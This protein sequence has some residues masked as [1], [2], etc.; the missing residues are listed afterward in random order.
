MKDNEKTAK[1]TK[2]PKKEK[3]VKKQKGQKATK[4]P[5]D[6]SQKKKI[7]KILLLLLPLVLILA[8]AAGAVYFFFFR[9]P[10]EEEQIQKLANKQDAY[11]V[12]EDQVISLEKALEK[13][14]GEGELVRTSVETPTENGPQQWTFHYRD[15][16]V[17]RPSRL[18]EDYVDVLRS[19]EEGFIITDDTHHQLAEDPN[20]NTTIGSVILARASVENASAE[21]SGTEDAADGGE[22]ADKLLQ[23]I[24]AWSESSMAIRISQPEGAILPPVVEEEESSSSKP[25]EPVAL[26]AQ[27]E[28]F[29]N[30]P[31]G[32]LGL[33]GDS[34]AEYRVYPVEGWVRV[35]G[36]TCR[37]LNVYV[38]DMPEETNTFMGTF[39]LSSDN[40]R[41]YKL[42]DATGA[43][44]ELDLS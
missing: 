14:L 7:P 26:M 31:A 32:K 12:G 27:L 33:P 11:V 15:I 38:L 6:P 30:L 19:E 42:D 44:V 2:K 17:K 24:L 29:N 41:L 43:I 9:T 28:Y 3:K 13:T 35:S 39:Y 37:V 18:V 16:T 21:D 22:T 20:L 23:L 1:A 36:V 25:I 10:S 34:M 40:S 8:A 4:Q 5:K